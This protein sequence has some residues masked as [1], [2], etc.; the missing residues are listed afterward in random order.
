MKAKVSK[1]LNFVLQLAIIVVAYW[2]IYR[3]L[4]FK[5]DLASITGVL[6]ERFSN[7]NFIMLLVVVFTLMFLNWGLEARKW[8]YLIG[9][10]EKVSWLRS[11]K[12]VFSGI[13]VSVFMPNRVGEYFG[14]VFILKHLHPLKGVLITF[15]GNMGQLLTTVILGFV[16][17]LL[18][19]PR[20]MNIHISP[21]HLIYW[22]VVVTAL[23]LIFFLILLY[24]NFSFVSLI[25]KKIV[26]GR[27]Q[28]IGNYSSVFENYSASELANVLLISMARYIVFT[29]QFILLL[30]AFR[31]NLPLVHYMIVIPVFFLAITII[32]TI[33]L[34]EPGIRGSLSLYLL[35]FYLS[36]GTLMSSETT[37]GIVAASTLLWIIN[38]AIPAVLGTFF[39]F[40][41]RFIRSYKNNSGT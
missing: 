38:L 19:L 13:T 5:R 30:L 15:M 3:E 29:T 24:L 14:R 32:P 27:F 28:Q 17:G 35:G 16:C 21:N 26:P 6:L 41:L 9:K 37:V 12:A 22:G 2:F 1:S 10:F 18:F 39:V 34:S 25:I 8:K 36:P 20:L 40:N 11:V 23:L 7:Q 4:F 31:V 33:A